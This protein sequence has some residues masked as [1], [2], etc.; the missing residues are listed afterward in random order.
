MIAAESSET[1]E[2][3]GCDMKDPAR[4]VN[5]G[6]AVPHVQVAQLRG[7]ARRHARI[8]RRQHPIRADAR[9]I[10][11]SVQPWKKLMLNRINTGSFRC[12]NL[13]SDALMSHCR[14]PTS[15]TAF[16]YRDR[17]QWTTRPKSPPTS[18]LTGTNLILPDAG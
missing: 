17:G 16:H 10:D 2:R 15:E 8:S 1:A 5:A 7:Y 9:R 13:N 18:R 14:M 12:T 4:R 11:G 3:D 6:M